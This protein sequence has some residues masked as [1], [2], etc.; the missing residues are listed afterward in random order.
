M[1]NC[2]RSNLDGLVRFW[3]SASC[4][5][6]SQCARIIRLNYGRTQLA[7]TSFLL[8]DSV[9]FSHRQPR[10]YCAK[11]SL[12][13]HQFWLT[14]SGFGKA[15][16]VQKQV[17]VQESSGP[18]LAHAS[19]SGMLTGYWYSNLNLDPHKFKRESHQ[20]QIKG[21]ITTNGIYNYAYKNVDL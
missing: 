8:S 2:P 10:S 18:L 12:V 17:S 13:P 6:A 9:A 1:Q 3:P 21:H 11:P 19:R 15:D 5:E 16:A 20:G 7:T 14:V 4:L